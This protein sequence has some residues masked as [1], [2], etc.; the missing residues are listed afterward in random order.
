MLAFGMYAWSW[1]F[2]FSFLLKNFTLCR[3]LYFQCWLS[4]VEL[5]TYYLH[6]ISSNKVLKG[7]SFWFASPGLFHA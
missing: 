2:F 5:N 3:H 1:S 4:Y 7:T 6:Y